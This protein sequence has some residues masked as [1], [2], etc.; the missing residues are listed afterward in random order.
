MAEMDRDDVPQAV[1]L[2]LELNRVADRAIAQFDKERTSYDEGY[3][4]GCAQAW[5][6]VMDRL[7][8]DEQRVYAQVRA[9]GEEA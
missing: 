9:A 3:M 5:E 7:T 8:E 1:A 6:C 4:D 2:A